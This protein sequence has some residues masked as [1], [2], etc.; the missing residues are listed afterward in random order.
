MRSRAS[1]L[2]TAARSSATMVSSTSQRSRKCWTMTVPSSSWDTALSS[3]RHR[4]KL[5]AAANSL[6]L[7]P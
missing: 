5:A 4:S 2:D 7:L 1:S 3:G 6:P